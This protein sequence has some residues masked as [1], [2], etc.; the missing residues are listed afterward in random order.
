MMGHRA[1]KAFSWRAL[2]AV[3]LLGPA[4]VAAT[5][6]RP[7]VTEGSVADVL[8]ELL[9]WPLFVGGA[10]LRVWATLYI[11]GR[12]GRRVTCEGPYSLCRHPLYIGTFLIALSAAV[13]LASPTVLVSV[14]LLGIAYAWLV[15]PAEERHLLGLLGDEY[16][17]YCQKTPRLLPILKKP[18]SPEWIDVRVGSLWLEFRRSLRWLMIPAI[19]ELVNCLRMDSHWPH[20]LNLP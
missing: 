2:I 18:Q 13:M 1:G 5:L 20:L 12:K 10:A 7:I 17:A 16:H 4:L 3:G 8:V 15:I 9:A 19:C 11:G 6:S 14:V